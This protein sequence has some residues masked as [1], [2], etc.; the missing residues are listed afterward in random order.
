V[1]G[2]A[3]SKIVHYEDDGIS[4]S[5][6][7][8]F[9]TTVI[10]KTVSGRKTVLKIG[11]REGSYADAPATR[12]ISVVLEGVAKAPAAVRL[13]GAALPAEAVCVGGG[14]TAIALPESP[15]SQ[16]LTVEIQM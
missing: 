10:E 11:A 13:N 3:S 12:C 1:P 2:K 15:A 4:Q 8:D 16:P 14:K 9:A 5:Y 6:V 7:N